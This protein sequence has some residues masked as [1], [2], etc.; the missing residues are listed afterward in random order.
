MSNEIK[1]DKKFDEEYQKRLFDIILEKSHNEIPE[2]IC[3]RLAKL[4]NNR[5]KYDSS[6]GKCKSI[7]EYAEDYIWAYLQ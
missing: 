7:E 1:N 6:Q 3:L 4:G 5:M 2:E